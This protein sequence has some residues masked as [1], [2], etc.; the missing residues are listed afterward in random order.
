MHIKTF[1]AVIEK[2]RPEL[3]VDLFGGSGFLSHLAK[4]VH[5]G[6]RVIYNDYD[7]YRERLQHIPQTNALLREFRAML[8]DVPRSSRL[9]APSREAVC[10]RL[11][12]ADKAGYVDWITLSSSLK[13]AMCY[14]TCFKEFCND[15]L[16][17]RVRLSDYNADGYL[18][19][20][21]AVRCDYRDL[22]R[23]YRHFPN[24]LFVADP[25]YLS[26]D[27]KT[28]NSETYWHLK[29]YLD[30]LGELA[31]LRFV[32]FTS[33]KSQILELCEWMSANSSIGNLFAG[34]SRSTVRSSTSPTGSYEDIM[35]CRLN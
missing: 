4:R 17:N 1:S 13:F 19:G 25:P 15:T 28:Y 31:G 22:L 33:E 26:T 3:V 9:G 23:Q 35:L 29:D 2:V 34:T 5:P 30:V 6:A 10:N 16:Y 21:E 7:N 27:T 32:Y 24:A 11:A 8:H 20:I 18:D 14:A 12:A